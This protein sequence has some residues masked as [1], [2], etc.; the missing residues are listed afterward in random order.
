V[1]STFAMRFRLYTI[2]ARPI[3]TFAPD[4]PRISRRG[5]PKIVRWE[6]RRTLSKKP[7]ND[8]KELCDLT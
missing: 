1:P 4:N 5:C 6:M 2:V 7:S 3:S 8:A